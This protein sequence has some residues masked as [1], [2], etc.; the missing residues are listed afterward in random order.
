MKSLR[1]LLGFHNW[2]RPVI[3]RRRC[4]RCGRREVLEDGCWMLE[5]YNS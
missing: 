5:S 1:C 3:H 2:L 4:L